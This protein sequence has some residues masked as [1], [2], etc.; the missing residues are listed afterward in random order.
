MDK[1]K[2]IRVNPIS[3]D[4]DLK[5]PAL[6]GLIEK[7]WTIQT[8]VILEDARQPEGDRHR[9]GLIMFP[10]APKAPTSKVWLTAAWVTSVCALTTACAALYVA[11]AG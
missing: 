11:F 6:H 7:G 4:E 8:S 9:L 5:D 1:P 10:P 2:V 3:L